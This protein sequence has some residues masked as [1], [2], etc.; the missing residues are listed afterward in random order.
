M[1][2]IKN[3]VGYTLAAIAGICFVEGLTLLSLDRS[4]K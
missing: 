1:P 4:V 3:F 2:T